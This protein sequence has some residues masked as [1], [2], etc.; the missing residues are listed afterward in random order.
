MG[1][2]KSTCSI[3]S[4]GAGLNCIP[5]LKH[6]TECIVQTCAGAVGQEAGT[7]VP[8]RNGT[9]RNKKMRKKKDLICAVV[10]CAIT[11]A[12]KCCRL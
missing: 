9:S 4:S 10:T 2:L 3:A 6:L 5:L 8:L 12:M 1:S 11:W 7:I